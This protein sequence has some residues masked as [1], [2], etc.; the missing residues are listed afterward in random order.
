MKHLTTLALLCLLSCTG[1]A[2]TQANN[3]TIGVAAID[4]TRELTE[5]QMMKLE[6]KTMQLIDRSGEAKAGYTNEF[7]L[8][9]AVSV[10]DS[11]VVEGGMQ[12]MTVTTLDVTFYLTRVGDNM[13]VM[14]TMTKKIK[15]SGNNR[16]QAISNAIN[17]INV[18]D[19]AYKQFIAAS[20]EKILAYYGENCNKIMNAATAA[21]NRHDYEQ[22]VSLLYSVPS[23]VPCH[24]QANKKA[25]SVY[26]RYQKQLCERIVSYARGQIAIENYADALDALN[27]IE[28]GAGCSAAV[29]DLIAQASRKVEKR[30]AQEYTAEARRI[31]AVETIAT[32]Y[33]TR[34]SGARKK[35]R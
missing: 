11:K 10:D 25:G 17:N 7:M 24:E 21:E 4:M 8:K 29:N 34:Q 13:V 9:P 12:Q 16:E 6:S 23:G 32:A 28:P 14:N 2:Q 15:G 33:Y 26:A 3:L 31:K 18:T 22:A 1:M 35:R 27:L 30:I 5:A 19:N 20:K